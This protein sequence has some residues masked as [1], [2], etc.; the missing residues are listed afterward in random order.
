MTAS[1]RSSAS[2]RPAADRPLGVTPLAP[3]AE[4][5]ARASSMPDPGCWPGRTTAG[6]WCAELEGDTTLESYMILLEAFLGD[7]REARSGQDR[8][9]LGAGAHDPRG[10]AAR[11]AA[12]RS[13]GAGRRRSPCRS[14]ATSRSRS[15]ASRRTRRTCSGRG[16]AIL[17]A[18]RRRARQHV[19]QISPG[20]LR[21]VPLDGRSGDSARDGVLAR[22]GRPSR[23][24]DMS[25]WSRTIFVPLSILYAHKPV[26]PLPA[27]AR[28]RASCSAG[29][30]RA[31]DAAA[32]RQAASSS[33]P[34][35][36]EAVLRR[37]SPAEDLRAIC[38]ARARCAAWRSSA[39]A[40][41]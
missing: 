39:P 22:A 12:G 7:R 37:R 11:R 34:A 8:A 33:E 18:G 15:R 10:D 14:S 2:F 4:R 19:H 24:Y 1:G 31:A 16:T 26:V 35:V 21:P 40:P 3:P 6:F 27:G 41:G 9:I 30:C 28:R 20:V 36:E 17:R 25:S 29:R 32:L 23:V 38:R 5:V 13:T